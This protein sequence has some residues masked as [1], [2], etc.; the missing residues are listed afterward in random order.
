[1]ILN[2]LELAIS[3]NSVWISKSNHNQVFYKV[4]GKFVSHC[5]RNHATMAMGKQYNL[6]SHSFCL[7][8]KSLKIFKCCTATFSAASVRDLHRKAHIQ[9]RT[10]AIKCTTLPRH[11]KQSKTSC[12][13]TATVPTR[14]A[15]RTAAVDLPPCSRADLYTK[16]ISSCH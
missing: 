3:T 14:E 1:M 9:W 16:D 15:E 13:M 6:G 7:L 8:Q 11:L 4:E 2:N 12:Q 10:I 5:L